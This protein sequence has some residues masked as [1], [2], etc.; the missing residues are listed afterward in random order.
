MNEVQENALFIGAEI[1]VRNKIK[2]IQICVLDFLRNLEAH[3]SFH[4]SSKFVKW[5]CCGQKT[6]ERKHF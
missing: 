4:T 6:V 1:T 2:E 5:R 3:I